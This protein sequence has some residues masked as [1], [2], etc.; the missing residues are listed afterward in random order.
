M[1]LKV[2]KSHESRIKKNI[3][4][5]IEPTQPTEWNN[6]E[7]VLLSQPRFET[8]FGVLETNSANFIR[9]FSLKKAIKEHQN[10][11]EHLEKNN[12]KT[13]DLREAMMHGT[14]DKSESI[15]ESNNLDRL[16]ERAKESLSY[17]FSD[18]ISS[19]DK[20]ILKEN[21]KK[22]IKNFHPEDLVN[23][24][25]L[26]PEVKINYNENALDPTSKFISD[27]EV[28][29]ANNQ[30]FMRDPLITTKKGIVIGN[31]KL[32]VRKVERDNV[33]FGLKQLGIEPVYQVKDPGTLEGGDFMPA[34][35]F[36]FQGQG[37]LSNEEGVNQ[38]LEN[39]VYGRVEVAVVKDQRSQM[40][41]MHLDTYFGLL[42]RD[43][44]L[45]CEDR[46]ESDTEPEVDVYQPV[47]SKE[48]FEYQKDRTVGLLTYLN[49][50]DIEVLKIS[51]EQQE[52][53]APNFL[54]V[55]EKHLIGVKQAGEK[56]ENKLNDHGVQTE[57]LDFKE[58]TGGYGGPHCMSQAIVRSSNQTQEEIK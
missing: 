14:I 21:F 13:I 15:I 55:E 8:L 36:V 54:L 42:S 7:V 48:D 4:S 45:L 17:N 41:E 5:T 34:G 33:L 56:F 52:N 27:F 2:E 58:L 39:K 16:R 43:L 3:S 19:S 38:L 22:T 26:R 35:D 25:L 44:A 11:R 40:D 18:E 23:I 6:A 37:L 32:D 10:Y 31:P 24:V 20:K 12:V 1:N 46:F 28:E 47:D 9:P 49:Q 29:P 51:K 53:Y 57:M 30:Y 50:K